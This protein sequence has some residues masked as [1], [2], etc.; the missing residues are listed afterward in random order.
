MKTYVK[1]TYSLDPMTVREVDLLSASWGVPKSEVIRRSVRLA[2]DKQDELKPMS[3]TKSQA[4]DYLQ[5]GSRLTADQRAQWIKDIRAE[6]H[7][8]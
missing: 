8:R 6:R 1:T 5:A 3:L 7:S 4:L 2:V